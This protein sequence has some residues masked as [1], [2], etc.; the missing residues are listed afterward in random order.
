MNLEKELIEHLKFIYGEKVATQMLPHLL[1][2]LQTFKGQ[3]PELSEVVLAGERVTEKDVILITYGDMVQSEDQ[4][5]LQTLGRFLSEYGRTLISTVHIL[6]FYPY[7]SD[8]GFA[9]IDYLMVD[10]ELGDWQDVNGLDQ[11]FRLMFDAVINHIS[12]ESEWFQGYLRADAQYQDYFFEVPP[13]FDTTQVFRPRALPL[14]TTFQTASGEKWIWTTFSND[15][16]DLNFRSPDLLV[17]VIEV[18][19]Q[20][21]ARGA[22]FIRLDAIA[23]I[24]KE[25]GTRCIHL[26]ETHR[27]IQ[28][29]RTL[30]DAVA[31]RVSIITET[32]VPH[33]ENIAYFG[34]GYNEAQMV[35]N[36]SLPPLTLHAFHTGNA[37]VLSNWAKTLTQPSDK[38]TFFN[39]LASHDG[40]GLMPARGY[41]SETEI[42]SLAQRVEATGGYV[43]YKNNP[44]GS[45]TAYELNINY[46]DA[47]VKPGVADES[48]Q[49]ITARFLASQSI[50][51]ALR[52]VP[53]IYFHSLFG[54][55]GWPEGVQQ[56]GRYRTINR[57]KLQSEVLERELRNPSTL[58]SQIYNGFKIMLQARNANPAFHPQGQ[59]QVLQVHASIFG[60][61]RKALD[62]TIQVLCLTNVSSRKIQVSIDLT[63]LAFTGAPNL[64]DLLSQQTYQT[65]DNQLELNIDPYQVLWL[66]NK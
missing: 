49:Q 31:P 51:L 55:R 32:N 65:T 17:E 41:L 40:I 60:L 62:D 24:W 20:Y 54:S 39:F 43:S 47:L 37:Q 23:F 18:L 2:R 4:V 50:M 12:A 58:R 44:D 10:P 48:I 27:L 25:S 61:L 35:Y 16:I 9:V 63:S 22:E 7:S 11:N 3:H 13:N 26:P 38:T 1:D 64:T 52:G 36:F 57:E 29:M 34:D 45:Q 14:I 42:M 56:T 59:Q 8:D 66:E 53:G 21:V 30:L 5:P 46:L 33:A 6:P 28:L 19:L 15:Q